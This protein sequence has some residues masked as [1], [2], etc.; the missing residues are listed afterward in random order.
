MNLMISGEKNLKY[1]KNVAI[2]DF[3]AD[4]LDKIEICQY[5]KDS[6]VITAKENGCIFNGQEL[7]LG[8]QYTVSFATLDRSGN[9]GKEYF[10]QKQC[11]FYLNGIENK[12]IEELQ[13]I[14][15]KGE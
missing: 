14:I 1:G 9:N 4:K 12:L 15:E 2:L 7:E 13:E 3:S 11:A 8:K 6:I 5:N 10:M